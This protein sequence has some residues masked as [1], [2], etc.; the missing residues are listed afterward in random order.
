MEEQAALLDGEREMYGLM[1]SGC[2]SRPCHEGVV[3]LETAR[4]VP[5]TACCNPLIYRLILEFSLE[6]ARIAGKMPSRLFGSPND[7]MSGFSSEK[8]SWRF[9]T[10]YPMKPPTPERWRADIQRSC[11]AKT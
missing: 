11:Q 7:V 3:H 10:D 4:N 6:K 8:L 9:S 5:S 2:D 1:Y